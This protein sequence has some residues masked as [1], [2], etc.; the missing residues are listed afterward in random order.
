MFVVYCSQC[1]GLIIPDLACLRSFLVTLQSKKTVEYPLVCRSCQPRIQKS[2]SYTIA[3]L[4]DSNTNC[5]ILGSSGT[6]PWHVTVFRPANWPI[7]P[8]Y[9]Q[10]RGGHVLP[11]TRSPHFISKGKG[12][13]LVKYTTWLESGLTWQFGPSCHTHK[14]GGAMWC[15]GSKHSKSRF[16]NT[17]VL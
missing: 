15:G 5:T 9:W 17:I 2:C 4:L 16:S 14:W 7:T 10:K 11:R 6:Y 3:T 1:L 8:E 13:W 12:A